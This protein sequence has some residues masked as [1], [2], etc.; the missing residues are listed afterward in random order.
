[1]ITPHD[2]LWGVALP[3]VWSL[4]FML[5]ASLPWPTGKARTAAPWGLALA[6]AGS[7]AIA[8]IGI[9][10]RPKFPPIEAEA[11]L[12]YIAFIPAVLGT[13]ARLL[14][15]ARLAC[16]LVSMVTLAA[17]AWLICRPA[18]ATSSTMIA[19]VAVG[20]IIWWG[21]ME[22]LARRASAA[23]T[24]LPLLFMTAAAAMVL[25]NSATQRYA[26]LAGSI[27]SSLTVVLALTWMLRPQLVNGG[28]L[29]VAIIV[30]GLLICGHLYAEVT[31]PHLLL[32]LT[33]ALAAWTGQLPGI[34]RRPRLSLIVNL[35]AV[36]LVLAFVL[37]PTVSGL[38]Q[39]YFA[40]MESTSY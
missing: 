3:L 31:I 7:F 22:T 21:A 37:V 40:Q 17:T 30:P 26:Q 35:I 19:A 23:S 28:V 25:L 8:Y 39:M 24:L 38:H 32:V 10:G 1:M 29:A 16:W 11:W 5:L 4:V 6:L 14:P 20:M 2:L 9:A 12:V 13:L 36:F 15:R 18:S 27:A 33:A 34:R